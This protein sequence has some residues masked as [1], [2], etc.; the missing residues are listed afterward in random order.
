MGFLFL[1]GK[2]LIYL[3]AMEYIII[4]ALIGVC[5]ALLAN[6]TALKQR[7]IKRID[8]AVTEAEMYN[9][10][11]NKA[12]TEAVRLTKAF[13]IYKKDYNKKVKEMEVLMSG[14][15]DEL[16]KDKMF[17]QLQADYKELEDKYLKIFHQANN[18]GAPVVA[19]YKFNGRQRIR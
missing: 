16:F 7:Y 8:D 19:K 13:D 1:F 17:H 9:A 5:L 2:K 11:K 15:K 14:K 12:V 6:N 3:N 10:E 18:T 4:F